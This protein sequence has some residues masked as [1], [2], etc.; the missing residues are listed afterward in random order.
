MRILVVDDE[1]TVRYYLQEMLTRAGYEAWTAVDGKDGLRLMHNL[2]PSLVL[3]DMS[4]PRMEG[5]EFI[6]RIRELSDIPVI[7]LSVEDDERMKV[8]AFQSGADDYV[9][10]PFRSG[11]LLARI[12]ANL[13]RAVDAPD[14]QASVYHDETLYIDCARH[15]IAVNGR[16][17]DL[18]PQEFRLLA[19]LVERPG[20]V[21][22]AERLM[23][24]CWR[25]SEGGPESVRVYIGYLRKKLREGPQ[26]P[27]IIETVR[28]FG[29]RYAPPKACPR[30]EE[31]W[32][33]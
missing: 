13:R 15:E 21:L 1:E 32:S 20:V 23:D 29:Y 27:E 18:T 17:V 2:R 12:Q 9:V 33:P 7:V 31:V 28:G 24:T 26:D 8:Q 25:D 3:T 19:A 5:L 10:K 14:E 11:E 22:S 30:R 4:M 6:G 16:A